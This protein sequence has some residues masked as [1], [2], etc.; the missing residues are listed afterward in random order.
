M[1]LVCCAWRA[2][3]L[4]WKWVRFFVCAWKSL[5]MFI[6]LT[7]HVVMCVES[8]AVERRMR[9]QLVLFSRL[10]CTMLFNCCRVTGSLFSSPAQRIEV[11]CYLARVTCQIDR[12]EQTVGTEKR[13]V[14]LS[15][16]NVEL[17]FQSSVIEWKL[18]SSMLVVVPLRFSC[19]LFG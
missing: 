17:H 5:S 9:F 12:E 15:F 16:V 11:H 6:D 13:W 10:W 18:H 1:V 8:V 7:S 14:I 3:K 2:E 19:I 4:R